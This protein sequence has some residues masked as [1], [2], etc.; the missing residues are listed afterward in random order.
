MGVTGATRRLSGERLLV[1]MHDAHTILR[2]LFEDLDDDQMIGPELETVN[3]PLWEVGHVAWF[4]ERWVLRHFAGREALNARCDGF[5]DSA[6]DIHSDRWVSCFPSRDST[7]EYLD[8]V[9]NGVVREVERAPDDER[10]LYFA[11]LTLFHAD[12]H[13]EAMLYSRQTLALRAPDF[14]SHP[15][16]G[17]EKSI[18]SPNTDVEVP[19]GTY[20]IGA[21]RDAEFVFD[22][23]K[24]AHPVELASFRISCYTVTQA[25]FAEFIDSGGYEDRSFWSADGWRWRCDTDARMPAYWSPAAAGGWKRRRFDHEVELEPDLPM[26]HTNW[27]E[28]Q[29]FCLWSGRRLPTE[30][31]WEVAAALESDGC[32]RCHPWGDSEPE[33]TRVRMDF[34]G[35]GCAP[36]DGKSDGDSF[37]GCRQMTGNVWEWTAS[38]FR[39]YPGFEV[40]PYREYSEPWFETRKV[41]R[42]G[43]WAT[44]SRLMRN[45][46][47][48]FYT[49]DRR[50]IWAGFRTCAR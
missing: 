31:E 19:G 35:G 15:L 6:A 29:A 20:F 25:Q 47:R 26:L 16:P 46:W 7:R 8:A 36:V 21:T 50:D 23:E 40:D 48:N 43:S 33:P 14:V 28:A 22:N 18:S 41:L 10:L 17:A 2:A 11:H 27:F 42:G 5:Y 49:P 4:Y 13:I 37:V 30:D 44:R 12:M 3:P 24:W 32:T 34:E 1:W 38:T 39:P 9:F 45:T